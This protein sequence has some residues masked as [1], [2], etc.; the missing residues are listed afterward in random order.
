MAYLFAPNKSSP[1]TSSPQSECG[2][3]WITEGENASKSR[4]TKVIRRMMSVM[5]KKFTIKVKGG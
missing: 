3:G 4:A 5:T 1:F 2:R